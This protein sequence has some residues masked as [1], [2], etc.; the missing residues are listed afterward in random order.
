MHQLKVQRIARLAERM[1]HYTLQ[2]SNVIHTPFPFADFDH[3]VRQQSRQQFPSTA[4]QL[5]AGEPICSDQ[6]V[7][8]R[9][10][11]ASLTLDL[12]PSAAVPG[13][14]KTVLTAPESNVFIVRLHRTRAPRPRLGPASAMM[15][16]SAGSGGARAN[17]TRS[18]PL[19]IVSWLD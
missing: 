4:A 14:C 15:T 9:E 17:N 5:A 1:Q 6:Y 16:G 11:H 12:H 18:C 2:L 19:S 13:P 7:H 3:N 10:V 8:E